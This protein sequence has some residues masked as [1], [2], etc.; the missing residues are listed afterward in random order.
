MYWAFA[1]FSFCFMYKIFKV[2]FI[3]RKCTT[4]TVVLKGRLL[5]DK[6][7]IEVTKS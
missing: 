7:K 2:N 3:S 6:D 5:K 1:Y 4:F